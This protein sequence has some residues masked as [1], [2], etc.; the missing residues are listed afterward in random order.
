MTAVAAAA[1]RRG[2]AALVRGRDLLWGWKARGEVS[3]GEVSFPCRVARYD[4]ARRLSKI[5]YQEKDRGAKEGGERRG[6]Q[7]VPRAFARVWPRAWRRACMAVYIQETP[8]TRRRRRGRDRRAMAGGGRSSKKAKTRRR[9][10]DDHEGKSEARQGGGSGGRHGPITKKQ[11]TATH[12]RGTKD[13]KVEESILWNRS[14]LSRSSEL[15]GQVKP[16]GELS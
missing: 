16:E 1:K 12:S 15:R 13:G 11:L 9:R 10:S 14:V 5:N 6:R 4:G 2:R 7:G 3:L 8:R